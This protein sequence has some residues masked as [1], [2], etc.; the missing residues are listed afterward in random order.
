GITEGM[1]PEALGDVG[2]EPDIGGRQAMLAVHVA[3]VDAAD[4]RHLAG[5]AIAIFANELGHW[6]GF[7][8]RAV[9]SEP[10]EMAD[11]SADQL[12][13]AFPKGG[14]KLSLFLRSEEIARENCR[15]RIR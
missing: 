11:E 8:G 7:H 14:E 10:G 1:V 15:S 12:S 13:L 5:L 3:M 2:G 9:R 4:G 6:P